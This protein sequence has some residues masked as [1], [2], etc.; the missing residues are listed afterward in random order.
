MQCKFDHEKLKVYSDSLHFVDLATK[1]LDVIPKRL[2]IHDQLSR[3]SI[4]I[5]LNIAEGNGKFSPKD[6][7]RFLDIARGSALESAACIDILLIQKLV[8][9]DVARQLKD[10]LVEIVRMLIGLIRSIS[11]DRSY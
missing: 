11:D 10:V 6:K 3:A 5:P 9:A 4:S 2:P 1:V 8:S 7:C